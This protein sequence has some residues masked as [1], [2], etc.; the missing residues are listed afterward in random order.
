MDVLTGRQP[1]RL[2]LA[3]IH[4]DGG[5]QPRVTLDP[6]V[7]A[8]YADLMAGGVEFPPVIVFDDGQDAWL[9]DGFHRVAAARQAGSVDILAEIRPGTRRDAVLYAVGANA[10]HGLR[11]TNDDKRR[12]VLTLLNDPEWT[13]WSDRAI[14]R[15]CR[16]DHK[17]VARMRTGHLGNSPDTPRLVQRNGTTFQMQLAPSGTQAHL[18]PMP[19]AR[20]P[21]CEDVFGP[22]TGAPA[23][24]PA[25]AGELR[26]VDALER[27]RIITRAGNRDWLVLTQHDDG[28]VE[29]YYAGKDTGTTRDHTILPDRP[30]V[31]AHVSPAVAEL[32]IWRIVEPLPEGVWQAHHQHAQPGLDPRSTSSDGASGMLTAVRAGAHDRQMAADVDEEPDELFVP[33]DG[34]TCTLAQAPHQPH[35]SRMND[36]LYSSATDQWA[37]PRWLVKT[38][39]ALFNFEIDV[40]ATSDNA[41]CARYFTETE[42]G[43]AQDWRERVCYCNPPYGDRIGRWVAK[44]YH[45]ATLGATVVCLVPARTDTRWFRDYCWA[46][47][48]YL[49]FFYGRLKFGEGT[50][51]APFPSV[52]AVFS[53]HSWEMKRLAH[54]GHVIVQQPLK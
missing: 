52:L 53:S 19:P 21:A 35:L 43:L 17:T 10:T 38:L 32:P 9:A 8:E 15:Q 29:L 3:H 18:P 45:E 1:I 48:R 31:V 4:T 23:S 54:L 20:T 13:Q 28:T 42:D 41:A 36:G 26:L 24:V 16:V 37:T 33:P 44:A 11:R 40:C 30:S 14:A 46:H 34:T 2:P 47:A 12:A 50:S 7:I 5:T 49:L 25:G 27:G 51:S 39:D 6:A 22:G